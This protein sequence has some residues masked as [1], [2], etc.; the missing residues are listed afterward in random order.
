MLMVRYSGD[1]YQDCVIPE[2]V[3]AAGSYPHFFGANQFLLWYVIPVEVVRGLCG[4]RLLGDVG[5]VD[6]RKYS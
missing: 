5:P 2:E 1:T 6:P 3:S 4:H